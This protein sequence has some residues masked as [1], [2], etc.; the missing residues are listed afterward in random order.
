MLAAAS[1]VVIVLQRDMGTMLVL[2]ASAVGMYYIAGALLPHM[3]A[4]LASAAAFGWLAIITFPHR[5]ERLT[6]F[7]DPS[8][9]PTGVG[10]HINQ[11]LIAIG[12][13]GWFGRGLGK[14]YQIYGYLPEASNDSIFA[15]I[16]EEFGFVGS[17]L[18]VAVF[19]LMVY[20]GLQIARQA[21]DNFSRLLATGITLWF[22]FQAFINISAM[23]A[24]VPLTGIPLPFISYG[25]SSLVVSLLA[26]GILLNISKFT[27]KEVSH[28]DTRQRGRNGW[29]HFA[30]PSNGR[31][32][33]VAR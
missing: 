20:R 12:S 22:G 9:D 27:V 11:A 21:P 8:H 26:A 32:A 17:V 7:L 1:V 31:R 28:A 24:L 2:A 23:L 33:K 13:G 19:A 3:I 25:G 10:Y 16:G 18:L 6:A 15:V 14:S 30:N 4:L 29:S 5:L